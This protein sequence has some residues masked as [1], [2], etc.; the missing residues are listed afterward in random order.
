MSERRRSCGTMIYHEML[1]ETDLNYRQQR[2][3][4][5]RASREYEADPTRARVA[6]DVIT[7][8]VVV[9]VVY[10]TAAQNISDAQIASQI[11]ILNEDYRMQNADRSGIPE[12]FKPLATDAKIE[13]KLAVRD[14]DGQPTSGITRTSTSKTSFD[15]VIADDPLVSDPVKFNTTG[16]KDAW[17]RDKYLNMWICNLSGGLLGYAQFPGGRA[18][19]DGVVM[20]YQYFGDIG[21]ATSPYDK[22]RTA[23]HEVG[24]WLNLGH[25]WGDEPWFID[26]CSLSDFVDDT[27][28][29]AGAN[30]GLPDF[31]H[32]TCNNG[33]NGDMFMNYMDY[34]DDAGMFMFTAGQV[35]RMRAALDSPRAS[36][37]TSNALTPP[38]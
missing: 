30:G 24:H 19:T 34:T 31:P 12:P 22:G 18:S 14:P 26:P 37:K 20:D 8:P 28:N 21:T 6:F 4:I 15:T 23:T 5:E 7:I 27:P 16:G 9:H 29:Q 2:L 17:P 35:A 32:I 25:I 1:M 10:N 11:R 13:F 33:P 36:I 3:S 38:A